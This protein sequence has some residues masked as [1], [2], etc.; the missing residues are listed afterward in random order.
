MGNAL[1]VSYAYH[2]TMAFK[3]MIDDSDGD[4]DQKDRQRKMLRKVV[5]FC[6]NTSDC[7][8]VQ[9]LDYF[10]EPFKA[11]DCHKTCDNCNSDSIF[12]TQ[13]F[14]KYAVHAINLVRKVEEERVTILHCVDI[15]R[16]SKS[17][18]MEQKGHGSLEEFGKGSKLER[19]NVERLFH[20]LLS[21]E[22][23]TEHHKVNR[24]G[25]PLEYVQVSV[26]QIIPTIYCANPMQLGK[27]S[28]E[29]SS[30]RRK[31]KLQICISS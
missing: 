18:K 5:Q 20:H 25:F 19:G 11:E 17:K 12:E 14:S 22:A 3:R 26:F 31:L 7:R 1:D 24:A 6:E 23:L 21:E 10:D 16:G 2:D 9:V 28:T 8:R 29:F 30:G 13:D 27:N 4:R 15:L